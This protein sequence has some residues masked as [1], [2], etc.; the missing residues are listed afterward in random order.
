MSAE[1]N[2]LTTEATNIAKIFLVA[3]G[4]NDEEV[5]KLSITTILVILEAVVSLAINCGL[6]KSNPAQISEIA[7]KPS[8]R[9]RL[10]VKG[11][12]FSATLRRG[13]WR[14]EDVDGIAKA[15]L[16]RAETTT[17]EELQN[18]YISA[19]AYRQN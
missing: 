12:V 11:H 4:A 16:K 1:Y 3:Q 7:R 19:L 6:I 15:I 10:I 18:L 17:A 14:T 13:G 5:K 2:F 9:Y 8:L